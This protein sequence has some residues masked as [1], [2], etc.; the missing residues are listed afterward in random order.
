MKKSGILTAL[1]FIL[2]AGSKLCAETVLPEDIRS[3]EITVYNNGRGLIKET[4]NVF[5][6]P[7]ESELKFAGVSSKIIPESL[8]LY[9]VDRNINV[10]SQSYNSDLVNRANILDRY[11]GK[12]LTLITYDRNNN[13]GRTVKAR[14][15]SNNDGPVYEIDGDIHIDYPGRPVLPEL[16]EALSK[17]SEIIWNLNCPES[18]KKSITAVYLTR[19]LNWDAHYNLIID[20]DG[21]KADINSFI[22]LENNTGTGFSGAGMKFIAGQINS[23]RA[24]TLKS[25]RSLS[26]RAEPVSEKIGGY[27]QYNLARPV[28]IKD[29]EKRQ[30]TLFSKKEVEITREYVTQSN[31]R[32]Y[33]NNYSEGDIRQDV[34][35]YSVFENKGKSGLGVPFPAGIIRVY[36]PDASGSIQFTGEERITHTPAGET[37]RVKTGAAFDIVCRRNQVDYKKIYNNTY[38][39]EWEITLSN[40]REEKVDVEVIEKFN[41]TWEI[42]KSNRE[43]DK[44]SSG[45]VKFIVSLEPGAEKKIKYRVRI[46]R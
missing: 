24:G 21:R 4:R 26:A 46:N 31:N 13:P 45:R 20:N 8:Y 10:L 44:I 38:E 35:I 19:G 18:F 3:L 12:E 36:E 22:N 2:I 1:F 14:L 33:L 25:V 17:K 5:L 9:A 42:T 34:N 30:V 40:R 15:I 7:G 28:S 41:R 32:Y 16:P 29:G 37:I 43:Y 6:P 23:A 11:I 27:Y 39:T